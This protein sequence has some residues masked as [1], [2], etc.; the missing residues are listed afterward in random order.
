MILL[1][2]FKNS[3]GVLAASM[4]LFVDNDVEAGIKV[5]EYQ[6]LFS[7]VGLSI[8][9]LSIVQCSWSPGNKL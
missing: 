2:G 4:T 3:Y 6:S 7:A 5:E 1:P 8:F 9:A